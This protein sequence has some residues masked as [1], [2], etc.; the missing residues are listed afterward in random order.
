MKQVLCHIV[1]FIAGVMAGISLIR[2]CC[3]SGYDTAARNVT[4]TLYVRDTNIYNFPDIVSE[5]IIPEDVIIIR[6]SLIIP[7][8]SIVVLPLQQRHYKGKDY[9]AWISGY[10]PQL[11]SIYVFPETRYITNETQVKRKPTRWGIGIQAGYGVALPDGRPQLAPYL[12]VGISYNF[13]RF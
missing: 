13:I 8:D 6:D 10:R 5:I 12:G 7:E 4:D 3:R 1:V 9:E 11:D 2:C